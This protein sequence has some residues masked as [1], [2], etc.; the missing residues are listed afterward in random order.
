QIRTAAHN[1][2]DVMGIRLKSGQSFTEADVNENRNVMVINETM[3]QRYF[4]GQDPI[5]REI[6]LGVMGPQPTAIR[7]VGVV[8]DVKDLGIDAAAEPE[9]YTPGFRTDQMLMIRT[10]GE[11]LTLASA[12]RQAVQGV[13]RDQPLSQMRSMDSAVAS[14]LARRRF[15]TLLLTLFAILSLVL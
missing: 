7:I 8:S 12:V 2:F 1:Y 11:P 5:G 4:S 3:A 13:D 10:D 6:L 15:S 14:S 9:I